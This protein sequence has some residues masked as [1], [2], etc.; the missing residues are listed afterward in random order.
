MEQ[1][2]P[3]LLKLLPVLQVALSPHHPVALQ[4]KVLDLVPNTD[5]M[6]ASI[7]LRVITKTVIVA[8]PK[9]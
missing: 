1:D 6:T 3:E 4:P 8:G 2:A 9:M 7:I 5:L